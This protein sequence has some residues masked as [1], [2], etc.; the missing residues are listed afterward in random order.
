MENPPMIITVLLHPLLWWLLSVT[1]VAWAVLSVHVG[2]VPHWTDRLIILLV[3]FISASFGGDLYVS[4][5]EMMLLGMQQLFSLQ[6]VLEGEK[7]AIGAIMA[8]AFGVIVFLSIR[9]IPVL[10]YA[11]NI[12]PFAALAYAVARIG[13]FC[14]GDDFGIVTSLPWGVVFG[15]ATE[16]Y[17][18]HLARGWINTGAVSSLTVHPTQLY[19]ALA[20][21]IGFLLLRSWQPSW[22]GSRFALAWV[23]YGFS[24][25]FIQFYR[26]DHWSADTLIDT[27][28]WFCLLFV[29]L[30][31]AMWCWHML[32]TINQR[33]IPVS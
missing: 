1:I 3:L 32:R 20:G 14:N 33:T 27:T 15:N 19:H 31:M 22:Q 29:M 11:D 6:L 17:D 26:D 12:V 23:Y 10:A 16:A 25:F 18:A 30:G 5:R 24:R 9:K 28:Q 4:F 7:G 13:C 8:S 21:F 2:N